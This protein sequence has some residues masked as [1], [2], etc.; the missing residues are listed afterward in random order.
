MKFPRHTKNNL[1][2][3][4]KKGYWHAG[5]MHIQDIILLHRTTEIAT[6]TL[7]GSLRASA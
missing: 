4:E 3:A 2:H 7:S 5:A 6:K 1:C